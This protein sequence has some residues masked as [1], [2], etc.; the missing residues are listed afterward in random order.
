MLEQ[1]T[2][3]MV[4]TDKW[5]PSKSFKLYNVFVIFVFMLFTNISLGII[6]FVIKF[7][8]KIAITLLSG[9]QS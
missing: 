7:I 4:T 9:Y 6:F 8:I 3:E 1:I 5:H 2:G